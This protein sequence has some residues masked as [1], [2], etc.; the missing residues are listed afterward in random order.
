VAEQ[1]HTERAAAIEAERAAVE[2][3]SRVED[4]RWEASGK[5]WRLR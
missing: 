5:N 4:N 1:E 2:Q 3:K